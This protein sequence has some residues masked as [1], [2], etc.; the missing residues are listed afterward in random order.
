MV[1]DVGHGRT[2][3]PDEDAVVAKSDAHSSLGDRVAVGVG[4]GLNEAGCERLFETHTTGAE[5]KRPNLG[6]HLSSVD[7]VCPT[8]VTRTK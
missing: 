1:H 8:L 4:D 3:D 7:S 6:V 2:Q 5:P